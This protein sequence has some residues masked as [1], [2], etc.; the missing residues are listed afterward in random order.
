MT[1]AGLSKYKWGLEPASNPPFSPF[2]CQLL[3]H[4]FYH[5]FML[6][7]ARGNVVFIVASIFYH[8]VSHP[9]F[10]FFCPLLQYCDRESS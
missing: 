3:A 9:S 6:I 10:A 7:L 1:N 5:H 8:F 2:H 4:F